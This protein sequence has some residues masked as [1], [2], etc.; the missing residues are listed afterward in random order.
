MIL[1]PGGDLLMA[2][3]LKMWRQASLPAAR[4]DRWDDGTL[5]STN[6][7]PGY[8]AVPPGWKPRLYVSQDGRRYRFQTG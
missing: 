3:C 1:V 6:G 4:K 5:K 8:D 7:F 2:A